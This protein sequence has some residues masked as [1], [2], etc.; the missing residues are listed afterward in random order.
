MALVYSVLQRRPG[1]TCRRAGPTDRPSHPMDLIYLLLLPFAGSLVA[2][3]LP[4]HARNAAAGWAA[5]VGAAALVWVATR[6][7]ALQGG[8]VLRQELHWLPSA[9]IDFSLRMDGFAW[10]FALLVTGIGT[11]VAMYE[12]YNMSREDTVQR[13]F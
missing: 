10:M 4:T 13:I 2:A 8:A 1:N 5:L 12:R 11:L 6:Y 7:P 9:G 3:L